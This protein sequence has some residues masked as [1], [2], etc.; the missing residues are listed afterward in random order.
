MR[1]RCSG[2]L[3]QREAVGE[4]DCALLR[5]RRWG[6][7]QVEQKGP[8]LRAGLRRYAP[9]P[10]M[11]AGVII[12]LVGILREGGF[13]GRAFGLP[14]ND[15]TAATVDFA[16]V[17]RSFSGLTRESSQDAADLDYPAAAPTEVPGTS[18]RMTR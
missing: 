8:L 4:V 9:A 13:S 3:T 6:Q 11:T 5:A 14:E 10:G 7:Q 15:S 1:V 18:P 12:A 16:P 17:R 2:F